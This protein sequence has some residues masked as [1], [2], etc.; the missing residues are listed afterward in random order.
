MKKD[1]LA[2]DVPRG[3]KSSKSSSMLFEGA[4]AVCDVIEEYLSDAFFVDDFDA[5]ES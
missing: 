2:V 5:V 4:L 1:L 3:S